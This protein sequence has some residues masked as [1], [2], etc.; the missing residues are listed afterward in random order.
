ME[1]REQ[2]ETLHRALGYVPTPHPLV[3]FMVQLAQPKQSPCAVLEPACGDARFLTAF[4]NRYGAHHRFVG[5]DIHLDIIRRHQTT[6]PRSIEIIHGDYLLWNTKDRF[7]LILG[8]PP[9]GIVGDES[10]YAIHPLK[11]KKA[12]YKQTLS[13]WKGKYNLY[14]AFIEKSVYLLK[15]H[16][17]LVFVVPTTWLVLDDFEKLRRFLAARGKLEVF[18]LGKVFPEVPVSAVV[19]RYTKDASG[20]LLY[21]LSDG[22]WQ[23]ESDIHRHT[24]LIQPDYQGA[25]IRFE[26]DGWEEF[27][28]IGVPLKELFD[29]RFAARSPEFLKRGLIRTQPRKGDVPVLTGRNLTRQGI[30]YDTCYSGWWMRREDGARLRAFYSVPRLVVGHTKGTR[31]VCAVDW[32]C[33]P[34]REEYQLIPKNNHIQLE[35][36][37]QYL[38]S[39]DIQHYLKHTYRDFTPHLTKSMLEIVPIPHSLINKP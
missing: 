18:Y 20:L 4:Q 32:R 30:D 26:T 38:N 13:T 23:T 37:A 34:W 19:L 35:T 15:P 8:N 14:G 11:D 33:Y 2:N 16:G 29:I 17:V 28:S 27:E 24:Q 25:M 6:L 31:L 21:D 7:D 22:L 3:E 10:H 9:Y 1:H 12:Q 36:I 39:D 5:I